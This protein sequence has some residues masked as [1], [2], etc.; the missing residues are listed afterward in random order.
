MSNKKRGKKPSARVVP[1]QSADSVYNSLASQ[2]RRVTTEIARLIHELP[3]D[4]SLVVNRVMDHP[5]DEER[6]LLDSWRL[7]GR[8]DFSRIP[9]LELSAPARKGLTP[10]GVACLWAYGAAWIDAAETEM[11][12]RLAEGSKPRHD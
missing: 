5:T 12:R 11:A 4:K 2:V 10:L 3:P 6:A 1:V 9:K 7:C 8:G